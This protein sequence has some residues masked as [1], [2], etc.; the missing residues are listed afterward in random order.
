M[1]DLIALQEMV[2]DIRQG[3]GFTMAPIN[4]LALL[5]E[6]VGEVAG[7][8]KRT[9][10]PNYQPFVQQEL[11]DELADVLGLVMALANQYDI[12]LEAALRHKLIDHDGKRTWKSATA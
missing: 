7:A 12:D 5:V 11:E 8:L 2:G 9:W 10:S 3:R 6:E 4:I 1:T